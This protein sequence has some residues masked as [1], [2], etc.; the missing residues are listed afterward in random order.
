MGKGEDASR[1]PAGNR[2]VNQA[3]IKRVFD[4]DNDD[5][6]S[7]PA[8][9]RPGQNYQQTNEK[10]RRTG[11][12]EDMRSNQRPTLQPPIRQS[13]IRKPQVHDQGFGYSTHGGAKPSIFNGNYPTAPPPAP[14]HA[15]GKHPGMNQA[16]QKQPNASAARPFGAAYPD[17]WPS[18]GHG[19]VP[20][21]QDPVR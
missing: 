5:E 7:R 4:P 1:A 18:Y 15:S 6:L 2:P 11:E 20:K 19:Q 14:I 10:R 8:G 21:R 16:Y 12:E 9:T 17:G 3:P 13:N